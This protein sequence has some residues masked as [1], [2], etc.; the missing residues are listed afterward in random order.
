MLN[1]RYGVVVIE[2]LRLAALAADT[3][4]RFLFV[5]ADPRLQGATG[6]WVA[7]LAIV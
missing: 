3:V 7:P 2:N 4:T 1:T 5:A 6:A